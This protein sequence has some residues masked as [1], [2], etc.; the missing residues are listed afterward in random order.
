VD[1]QFAVFWPR[2]DEWK[3]SEKGFDRWEPASLDPNTGAATVGSEVP[4][5]HIGGHLYFQTDAAVTV[6]KKLA[7]PKTAQPFC[8]PKCSTDYSSRP[9]ESRSRSPIRAFRTGVGKASQMVAT[10]MFELLHAIGADAKSI[11]FSD[12]RQD[13]ANQSLEIERL[14]LRD[15]R[16]EILVSAARAALSEAEA[17]YLTKD[18]QTR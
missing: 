12:S 2:R 5:G 9:R 14:H 7:F 10:E 15:L 16:R 18:Q 3:G 1:V 4:P 17:T 13:A 11:V 8:C 6:K